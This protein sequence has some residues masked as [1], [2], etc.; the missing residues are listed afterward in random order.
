MA[1]EPTLAISKVSRPGVWALNKE[2][3][4]V[5]IV[6]DARYEHPA[7]LALLDAY[8]EIEK[9]E[10]DRSYIRFIYDGRNYLWTFTRY[11]K[12]RGLARIAFNLINNLTAGGK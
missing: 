9:P 4:E 12:P 2:E 6:W 7:G 8:Y 3:D 5:G 11:Y 10:H 1:T